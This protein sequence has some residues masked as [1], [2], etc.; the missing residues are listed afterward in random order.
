MRT[1]IAMLCCFLCSN[2]NA[3]QRRPGHS[4]DRLNRLGLELAATAPETPLLKSG[5]VADSPA[6]GRPLVQSK[7]AK[8]LRKRLNEMLKKQAL[9][10]VKVGIVIADARSG[11]VWA[12][13]NGNEALNPASTMK[14]FTS[15]IALDRL[16]PDYRFS[17]ELLGHKD[18]LY[19]RGNGDPAFTVGALTQLA[20]K[21]EKGRH[22]KKLIVDP[23]AFGGGVL[24]PG[25]GAKKSRACYR[26]AVGA[27]ALN[28]GCGVIGVFPTREGKKA[29]IRMEPPGYFFGVSN[30]TRSVSGKGSTLV[31]KTKHKA[32]FTHAKITGR[33]GRKQRNGVHFRYRVSH[34]PLATANTLIHLLKRRGIILNKTPEMGHTPSASRRIAITKS[35][36]LSALISTMNKKSNNF[37][38]E[39]LLRGMVQPT[40]GAATWKAGQR[41]A[42]SWISK[43]LQV[44][45]SSFEYNNGSG[46]YSGGR[47]SARQVV[48][49]LVH[50]NQHPARLQYRASLSIAGRDGTLINRLRGNNY[51]GRMVGKTGTLNNVSALSGYARNRRGLR[52]AFSILM[53][54]TGGATT[55][56]R[57]I[58]NQIAAL[59]IES[60]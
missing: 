40:K 13:I 33:I 7:G 21:V 52:L 43:N 24:P 38:A 10:R 27:V 53:N 56:M 46:L 58:Q 44:P 9:G 32:L 60:K 15:A 28:S 16:G 57:K 23:F 14:L 47:F 55:R 54:E 5:K 25:Y 19:L 8:K 26:A 1:L 37:I 42:R 3:E 34:P 12:R 41:I 36:P 45:A 35:A 11:A 4:Y 51:A 49:L 18:T 30:R 22:F 39:M 59:I 17:T 2:L 50:M 20:R 29:L 31:V 48:A 6:S